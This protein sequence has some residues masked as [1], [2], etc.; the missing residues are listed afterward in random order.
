MTT[1]NEQVKTN[2]P[3]LYELITIDAI[4]KKQTSQFYIENGYCLT[5]AEQHRKHSDNGLKQ[6]STARRWEQYQNGEITRGKAVDFAVARRFKE[7]DQETQRKI[8]KLHNTI[9]AEDIKNVSISVIWRRNKTWGYNPAATVTINGIYQ[10]TGTASGCGYDKRSAAVGSALNQSDVILKMLYTTKEKAL[11]KSP[12]RI[13][14]NPDASN[15]DLIYYGAGYGVL[16]HFEG[17]VGI[18]SFFHVFE[19]CGLKLTHENGTDYSDYYY[20]ERV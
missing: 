17:G 2:Y 8:E 6:H 7:I 13:R 20:I 10:Y 14:K 19:K 3:H 9:A 4:Q 15:S 11:K 5:W 12:A 16:P 1:K 18:T